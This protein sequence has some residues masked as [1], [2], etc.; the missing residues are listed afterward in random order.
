MTPT[1]T[2]Y[3]RRRT[4]SAIACNNIGVTLL[5]R[6]CYAQAAD[7]FKQASLILAMS[8]GAMEGGEAQANQCLTHLSQPRPS[9]QVLVI[10]TIH[11][12]TLEDALPLLVESAPSS[13]TAFAISIEEDDDF[14]PIRPAIL[15]HNL[16]IAFYCTSLTLSKRKRRSLA[17]RLTDSAKQVAQQAMLHL[18]PKLTQEE[19]SSRALSLYCLSMALLNSLIQAEKACGNKSLD[20]YDLLVQIRD[21]ALEYSDSFLTKSGRKDAC[22]VAAAAA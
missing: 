18:E 10:E 19:P 13:F 5:N 11:T 14:E 9:K 1:S 7:A 21:L 3:S 2:S 20:S 16:G 22:V 17:Q 8:S 12:S 15:A 6:Q 4:R